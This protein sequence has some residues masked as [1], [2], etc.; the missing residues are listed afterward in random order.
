MSE[1][2]DTEAYVSGYLEEARRH[3]SLRP[4]LFFTRLFLYKTRGLQYYF[5]ASIYAKT[6]AVSKGNG[7]TPAP[8]S[9]S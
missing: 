8:M 2:K 1:T 6:L 9:A 4:R 3:K 7:I 5:V